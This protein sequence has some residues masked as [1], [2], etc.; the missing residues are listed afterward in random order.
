MKPCNGTLW[1]ANPTRPGL[2]PKRFARY[3]LELHPDK[4][5]MLPFEPPDKRI[6]G[7]SGGPPDPPES[8]GFLGFTLYWRRT[9][10]GK[11][12]IGR[13]TAKS[14][15]RRTFV[16]LNQWLKKHRHQPVPA[17]HKKLC[18]ALRGH[19]AYFGVTGNIRALNSVFDRVTQMWRKWLSRRSGG[20]AMRW[21]KFLQILERYPLPRPRI[22]HSSH[23]QAN[24]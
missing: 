15:L 18:A 21:E 8:F 14:R 17:Q 12:G 13:K 3:G 6:P 23:R 22:V 19:Y 1:V 20:P 24:P 9:R 10:K 5:R 16:R 2:L 4:T 11:W 7:R